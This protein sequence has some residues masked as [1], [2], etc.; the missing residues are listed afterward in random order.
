MIRQTR[1]ANV[2]DSTADQ[3]SYD[4]SV[5][6]ILANRSI[7]AWILKFCVDEFKP[8][9]IERIAECIQGNPDVATKAVH[10]NESDVVLDGNSEIVGDNSEDSSVSES[11]I[12]YDLRFTAVVPET[13][14]VVELL[15]NVEAQKKMQSYKL[16]KRVIYYM[17]RLIS[18]Q[19]GTVFTKSD[20]GKIAKVYSIWFCVDTQEY[21][22]NTI[23]KITLKQESV[24]GN[25]R[26]NPEATDLMQGVIVSL[27]ASNEK[28]DNGILNLMN[29]LLS[30]TVS[31][32]EK[33]R[34]LQEDFR[35]AIT[36]ELESE[37]SEM[38]NLSQSIREH[39]ETVGK[40]IGKKEMAISVAI[41]MIE[42]GDTDE[43]IVGITGLSL[44]EVKELRQQSQQSN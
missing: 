21:M 24:Y 22:K 38:C 43:R 19:Y 5:K 36:E 1:I 8:Y 30:H 32:E 35:I 17:S 39:A 26:L 34:M 28:V 2:V 7:L 25:P 18:G 14:G 27:G 33:K 4:N 29:T 3:A 15:I 6:A 11:K 44:D 9:D 23:S 13:D 20:Y 10:R 16:E 37:V 42:L 31:A 40:A 41:K 12:T